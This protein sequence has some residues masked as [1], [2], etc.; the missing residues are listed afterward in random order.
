MR[1]IK[2]PFFAACVAL[3]E[4]LLI[5]SIS[6]QQVR[7]EESGTHVPRHI[8]EDVVWDI[9]GSPYIFE[10]DVD[11]SE[12]STLRILPG[13]EIRM[14][15][16]A[17]PASLVAYGKLDIEGT[18]EQPVDITGID[19]IYSGGGISVSN[20]RLHDGPTIVLFR[21]EATL[22]STTISGANGSALHITASSVDGRGLK[23][24]NSSVNGIY[25][26]LSGSFDG[27]PRVSIRDS[28]IIGNA[29]AVHNKSGV[30]LDLENNWWGKASGPNVSGVNSIYGQASYSPWLVDDPFGSTSCCSSLLFIP[31]LEGTRLYSGSNRLWEPNMN[32]DVLKL[33]MDDEGSSIDKKIFSTV[34]IDKALGIKPIYSGFMGF[35]GDLADGGYVSEAR[36]FGYDWRR[37]IR[38]V[39]LGNEARSTTTEALL[40]VVTAM[41][42]TSKTGKVSLIAHSNGGLIAKYLVKEL[43]ESGRSA[44]I[45][46]VISVAVPYLGTPAALAGLLHGN[47]QSI[48]GGFILSNSVARGLGENMP[49]AY[50]LLP[51]VG[52]FSKMFSPTIAFASTTMRGLNDGTYPRQIVSPSDQADFVLD[53]GSARVR[54]AVTDLVRPIVGNAK[55][56]HAAEVLH[57]ILDPY[58]WPVQIATWAIVGWNSDTPTGIRYS[59]K[60]GCDGIVG[61]LWCRG[62]GFVW[63]VASSLMGDGTVLSLSAAHD[64][65]HAA[66]VDLGMASS[67]EGSQVDHANIMESPTVQKVIKEVLTGMSDDGD[68]ISMLSG[69][70]IKE[71]EGLEKVGFVTVAAHSSVE[72]H[73]YDSE[74]RHTGL[75]LKPESLSANDFVGA[76]YETGIPGSSFRIAGSGSDQHTYI[77]LPVT[78]GEKYSVEIRGQDYG[79]FTYDV[80]PS[81]ST[82]EGSVRMNY[83]MAP[84]SPLMLATTTIG[85][86]APG[87]LYVDID[88]DGTPEYESLPGGNGLPGNA[89]TQEEAERIAL[90]QSIEVVNKTDVEVWKDDP[91]REIFLEE[92]NKLIQES[93]REK[94]GQPV[95]QNTPVPASESAQKTPPVGGGVFCEPR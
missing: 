48:L 72:L 11:V 71:P 7:A 49:S 59:E 36:A 84:S 89:V 67:R 20:A 54:P 25:V 94:D 78:N 55:L 15:D 37:P 85:A 10:H 86:G 47:G 75:I 14:A 65:D 40:D 39:V 45:D 32:A 17:Q 70:T 76:A 2:R 92:V 51:S 46:K 93:T 57:A 18:A 62:A 27:L 58:Q 34:P 9:S 44:L 3:A 52:Y 81:S 83:S 33:Y 6:A 74:Y 73:V 42:A 95:M 82:G 63:R 90:E 13:V 87:S 53:N 56:L 4:V 29:V 22:A 41:A 1:S 77:K 24:E 8:E 66:Y 5:F 21:S 19:R 30:I 38:D 60:Q 80:E 35:L 26:A 31:G 91:R 16:G 68:R 50:S 64:S 61:T 23:I 88:D 69:V 43:I 79:F 28:R 12:D